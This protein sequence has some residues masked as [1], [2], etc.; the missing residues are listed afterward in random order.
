MLNNTQYANL[1][2]TQ[3]IPVITWLQ[4]NLISNDLEDSD[5][6]RKFWYCIRH[7]SISER[8]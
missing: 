3:T 5:R 6:T 8:F 7:Y 1:E 2:V 4:N